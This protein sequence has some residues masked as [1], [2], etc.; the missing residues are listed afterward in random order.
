MNDGAGQHAGLNRLHGLGLGAEGEGESLAV[1]LAD[2]DDD[3]A[4]AGLVLGKPA[5]LPI[6]LAVLGADVAAK[7]G[8]VHLDGARHSSLGRLS[9]DSL[10]ELVGHH[11]RRPVLN[12]QVAGELE[13]AVALGAVGEDGDGEEMIA[14]RELARR[15]DGPAG[16]AVLVP[17][18]SAL[19]QLASGDERV[20]EAAAA[21]AEWLTLSRL[22]ADSLERLPSRVIGQAGD[23]NQRERAGGF[24]EE[25]VLSH[26]DHPDVLR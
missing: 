14:D 7:V 22:P 8:P 23:L 11:E 1:T 2:H 3:A 12:V 21:R 6:F 20:L 10:T 9:R 17:A 19:E 26:R 13:S 16:D 15:E 4:L 18:P 25:K 24:G 5:V